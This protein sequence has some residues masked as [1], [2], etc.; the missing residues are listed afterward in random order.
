[1]HLQKDKS[2]F[3]IERDKFAPIFGT[4]SADM[5][6]REKK[7]RKTIF[8]LDREIE[9]SRYINIQRPVNPKTEEPIEPAHKFEVTLEPDSFTEEKFVPP[10][11]TT[12]TKR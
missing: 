6:F 2:A 8:N 3:W 7:R 5:T 9:K 12:L 4:I 11:S 1:M 10:R